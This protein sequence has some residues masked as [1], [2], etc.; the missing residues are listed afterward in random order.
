[1]V[2]LE[3]FQKVQARLVEFSAEKR[4][5]A[6]GTSSVE[7]KEEPA[8]FTQAWTTDKAGPIPTQKEAPRFDSLLRKEFQIKGQIGEVDQKDKLSF[9]SLVHQIDRGVARGYAEEV[10]D[11]IINAMVPGLTLRSNVV[12]VRRGSQGD[13]RW[14]EKIVYRVVKQKDD[15]L[16]VYV[17]TPEKGVGR[18]RTLQRN[19]LLP[20]DLLPSDN[21]PKE[22]IT[23]KPQRKRRP[24]RVRERPPPIRDDAESGGLNMLQGSRA[25]GHQDGQL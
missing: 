3:L 10:V 4:K 11:A 25:G 5:A 17:V 19:H 1:M 9:S 21:P 22:I 6:A 14:S 23:K 15:S 12:P 18:T 24:T 2:G 16:P 13:G 7:A 20:C 8:A